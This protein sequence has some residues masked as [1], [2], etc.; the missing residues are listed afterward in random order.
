[1]SR[2]KCVEVCRRKTEHA[3]RS[4]LR[5]G[6]PCRRPGGTTSAFAEGLYNL[7]THGS[8]TRHLFLTTE[9]HLDFLDRLA[10]TCADFE[11]GLLDYVLTG[12]HYHSVVFIPD[13]RVSQALQRLYAE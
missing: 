10:V 1:V 7:A 13:R 12:T 6:P 3:P 4:V 11:F 2:A 5:G 8:D 9:D